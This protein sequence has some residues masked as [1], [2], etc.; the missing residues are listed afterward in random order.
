MGLVASCRFPICP[1]PLCSRFRRVYLGGA[2][3][4]KLLALSHSCRPVLQ[5]EK[6]VSTACRE[7]TI[8]K[9][10]GPPKGRFC[11]TF[12]NWFGWFLMHAL[13][14]QYLIKLPPATVALI[15][16]LSAIGCTSKEE[17]IKTTYP[18]T[19]VVYSSCMA[20]I[21]ILGCSD[22]GGRN[23]EGI[24]FRQSMTIHK[25]VGDL[26]VCACCQNKHRLSGFA[27]I[28][29]R[30]LARSFRCRRIYLERKV[31]YFS[32]WMRRTSGPFG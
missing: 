22:M 31:L 3:N 21:K 17:T 14:S 29:V 19:I 20:K 24:S 2:R 23:Q 8:S 10:Q 15:V 1:T 13:R 28:L 9:V 26:D 5:G 12:R 32:T 25:L 27:R 4:W 30:S 6:L 11:I 7:D 18:G 16:L